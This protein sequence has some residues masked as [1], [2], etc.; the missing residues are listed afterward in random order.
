MY[1]LA[2]AA[3]SIGTKDKVVKTQVMDGSAGVQNTAMGGETTGVKLKGEDG[4][5]HRV[6]DR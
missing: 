5:R 1:S 2:P 6:I 3:A 4:M